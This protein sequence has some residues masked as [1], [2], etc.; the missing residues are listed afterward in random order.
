VIT[1]GARRNESVHIFDKLVR[2]GASFGRAWAAS[3]IS[4]RQTVITRSEVSSQSRSG[5]C[6]NV[7]GADASPSPFALDVA[8]L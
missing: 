4:S 3:P 2:D 6:R 1:R 8:D 7:V 5:R